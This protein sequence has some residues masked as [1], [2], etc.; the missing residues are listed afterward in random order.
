[1]EDKETAASGA[2]T[3]NMIDIFANGTTRSNSIDGFL[4]IM[5]YVTLLFSLIPLVI[6]VW[7]AIKSMN[8]KVFQ[9]QISIFIG[10]YI[11]GEL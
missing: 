5:S 9:F 4:N 2:R 1:M 11:L 10:V 6:F 7:F 3:E 8:I